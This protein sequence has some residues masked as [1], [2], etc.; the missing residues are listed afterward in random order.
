M[1][2]R[3]V[4]A[5]E[6]LAG[7]AGAVLL[8]AL[9][10][11]WYDARRAPLTGWQAF[12][13]TDVLLALLALS[14]PLLLALQATRES[15]A[16]PTAISIVCATCGALATAVVL[17]RLVVEPQADRVTGIAGGAWLG[18]AAA[19]ALLAGGWWSL[20]S[21]RTPGATAPPV[22]VRPSPPPAG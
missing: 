6:W 7:L 5:G 10:L 14:G 11:D 19:L 17:V 4:R 16:L 20:E 13:V 3:R 15:P 12:A 22:E 18:L 9:F 2:L 1:S 8:V 21:E